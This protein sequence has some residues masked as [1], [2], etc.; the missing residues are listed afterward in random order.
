[1]MDMF[2]GGSLEHKVMERSGYVDY[3]ATEWELLNHGKYQKR[4]SFRFDRSLSRYGALMFYFKLSGQSLLKLQIQ[5]KYHM[6]ST[7]LKPNTCSLKVLLGIAWLK[8]AKHQQKAA[9]NA[10]ANSTNILR[11]IFGEIEKEITS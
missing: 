4:I 2:S 1:M 7:P 6:T 11:E 10:M 9:K 8:G 3:T 5:L